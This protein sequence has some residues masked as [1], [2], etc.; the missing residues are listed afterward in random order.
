MLGLPLDLFVRRSAHTREKSAA[1]VCLETLA[2]WLR[3]I[4]DS[5][6]R[7]SSWVGRLKVTQPPSLKK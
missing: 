7:G 5:A 3:D 2:C 6:F 1:G 4:R